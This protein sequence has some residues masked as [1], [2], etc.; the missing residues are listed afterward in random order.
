MR[1]TFVRFTFLF[2][3]RGR[4]EDDELLLVLLLRFRA[5]RGHK[6]P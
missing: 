6:R 1:G 5:I 4:E 2:V 3:F